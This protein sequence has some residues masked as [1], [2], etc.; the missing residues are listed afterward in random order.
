MAPRKIIIDTD[1]G[2]GI[3]GTDADDPIA[4]YLAVNDP[5]LDLIGVTT[6]FGNCPPELSAR[7]AGAVLR[8]LGRDDIPVSIGSPVPLSGELPPQLA[9]AYAGARGRPGR[10]DLPEAHEVASGRTAEDFIVEAVHAHPGEVTIVAI[11]PQ[12]N[13]ARALR[14]DPS[15]AEEIASVVF[16]GG[17]LGL[18]REYGRGN[19]TP[20][21]ECNIYFDPDAAD[22]VFRS[23]I[24]LTMI[25][26]DV[27][28]PNTGLLLTADAIAGIDRD[29][30]DLALFA[31]ICDTY[32]ESPMF[33]HG[34]GCVLYDPLAV[35]V[36]ADPSIGAFERMSLIVDTSDAATRGQ[37]LRASASEPNIDVMV[38]VD[39]TAAVRSIVETITSRN[40]T[41]AKR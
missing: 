10:I 5:R 29:S 14:K 17:G 4:L 37:T 13:L 33:Q 3:P 12:T 36:A 8:A 11:G 39:G 31:E 18:D 23:G 16:M 30:T 35:A 1:P 25:G 41:G 28:N 19:V 22:I 26:L 20:V 27:T 6:T 32:L 21:A 38:Q 24:E 40:T 2:V 9:R 34:L 15:L 7:G